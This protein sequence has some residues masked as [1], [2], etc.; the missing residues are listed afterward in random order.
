MSGS[1]LHLICKSSP[2]A[3]ASMEKFTLLSNEMEKFSARRRGSR[4]R[5]TGERRREN[6]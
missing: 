6:K 2:P 1:D 3:P 5:S 4:A